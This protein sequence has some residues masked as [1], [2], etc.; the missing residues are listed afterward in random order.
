MASQISPFGIS[1]FEAMKIGFARG[2]VGIPVSD[3]SGGPLYV[4]GLVSDRTR[5]TFS[6]D[7]YRLA[8]SRLMK[9]G[10][11]TYGHVG[12]VGPLNFDHQS[13]DRVPINSPKFLILFLPAEHTP[14]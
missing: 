3:E 12:M 7:T 6:P 14:L 11:K 2:C 4:V 9:A 10:S 5:V 1:N 13:N 8:G